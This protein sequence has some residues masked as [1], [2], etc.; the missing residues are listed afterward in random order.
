MH[1]LESE[2]EYYRRQCDKLQAQLAAER[3]TKS[4]IR[5][6]SPPTHDK[7]FSGFIYSPI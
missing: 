1:A 7:V 4:P 3:R 6:I 5:S 2:L